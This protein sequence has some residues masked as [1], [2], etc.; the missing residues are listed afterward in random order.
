VNEA[1]NTR[2]V[3]AWLEGLGLAQYAGAFAD[4]HIDTALLERLTA[5]D[6]KDLGVVSVGHRKRMLDSIVKL[7]PRGRV[8]VAATPDA[9]GERRQVTILFADLCSFTSLSQAMDAEDLH[10]LISRYAALVDGIVVAYGGS[11]D[12]HI[13]DAVMALFGAPIAHGDDPLRAVRAALDIHAGI[14]QL[15]RDY[16]RELAA[17]LGIASGEVV[18]GGLTGPG[19]HEYTVHG[20]SVNLAARLVALAGPGQT[21]VS[22][23]VYRALADHAQFDALGATPVKGFDKPVAVWALRSLAADSVSMRTP[24]VG[25]KLELEQFSGILGACKT[26]TSGQVVVIRGEAGIGK[27]RLLGEMLRIARDRGFDAHR[28][29]VFDFGTGKGQDAIRTLVG[30]LLGVATAATQDERRAARDRA[31]ELGLVAADQ[32]L[33]LDDLLGVVLATDARSLYDAMDNSRRNLGKRQAL[34][35]LIMNSSRRKPLVTAIE[36]V[37]WADPMT[38]GYL[39][40]VAA[41][42]RGGPALLLLTTRVEGDPLDGAWRTGLAGT[43]LTTI[44]VGPLAAEEAAALAG[45]FIEATQRVAVACLE[46]AEGN[47][48]FLEQLLRHAEEG[49]GDAIPASIQSLV[50]ARMDRLAGADKRALQAAAILGQRFDL[51]TLRHLLGDPDYECAGLVAHALVLPEESTFLFAHALVQEGVYSSLLKTRRR[52]L[53][54][55]AAAWFRH[56]DPELHAEHLDRAEDTGAARAFGE[57]ARVQRESFHYER[58]LALVERGLAVAIEDKETFELTCLKGRLLRD[59]GA[60]PESIA[61]FRCALEL[62]ADDAS[63]CRAGIGLAAGLRVSEG[64][65]EALLVL[66]DAQAAATRCG[67]VA[68]LARIHHLRGNV[69]FPMGRI[70]GCRAEH[71]LGLRYALETGSAQAEARALG[72]LGDAAYAQGRLRS[73]FDYFSRCVELSRA[74]GFG[75]IEV[76]NRSM[77]GFSRMCLN[78]FHE[79]LADGV[80][81]AEAAARVGQPRAEM[82]GEGACAFACF[83]LGDWDA[84]LAHLANALRLAQ[85]LGARRFEAQ[86][87]EMEGRIFWQLGQRELGRQRLNESLAMCRSVGMQFTGP[88]VIG[89]LARATEDPGEQR[90]LLDEGEALLRLGA[91]AHNHL[92]FYRDAIEAMIARGAWDE[93]LRYATALRDYTRE[94]PL[95]WCELLIAR[96]HALAGWAGGARDA[97][98]RRE[99][100]ALLSTL[101]EVGLVAYR[102]AVAD[103]LQQE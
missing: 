46:R 102:G 63:R 92:W 32:A 4:N 33:F 57:A 19:R 68:E 42:A 93:A 28:T 9:E 74:H 79:A 65:S 69:Y 59:L 96:T 11:I 27:S 75:R 52:E 25:R 3:A 39:A 24:F 98:A 44:D 101:D 66:D 49:A 34:S 72:G 97:A 38:L 80:A 70:E 88:A 1:H 91:V 56:S 23:A 8:A 43:P 13:G 51:P 14:T 30:D 77:I 18:A 100:R 16:G 21:L 55:R 94:E 58:A 31:L 50:L 45:T 54:R 48:L 71:E 87:R 103:A 83:E 36:D 90:R 76:A 35:A 22:D 81:A 99:L 85:R 47:P 20:D 41:A 82:L 86:H 61:A 84:A 53:H 78:Q 37:H 6:L 2:D 89:A 29:L 73:A 26:G 64:L 12:K 17:H 15:A 62:G 95:P 10:E 40:G 5:D 67:A 7:G 60:I